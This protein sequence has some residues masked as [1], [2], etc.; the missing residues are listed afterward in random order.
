MAYESY[1]SSLERL[2]EGNEEYRNT[3]TNSSLLTAEGSIQIITDKIYQALSDKTDIRKCEWDNAEDGVTRLLESP[4]LKE[5]ADQGKV[6]I[7]AAM[8]DT[9]SGKVEFKT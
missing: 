3:H 5:Q 8:Y 4:L 6:K 7:V 2:K 9:E 1:E